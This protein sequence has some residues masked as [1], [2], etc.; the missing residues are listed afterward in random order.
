MSCP[1]SRPRS[2]V[3]YECPQTWSR[4]SLVYSG[5]T[6]VLMTKSGNSE[7]SQTNLIKGRLK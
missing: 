7:I 5:R 2:V 6:C 1:T 4:P 3:V